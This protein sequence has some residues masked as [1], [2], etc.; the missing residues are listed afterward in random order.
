[1]FL[2]LIMQAVPLE[3]RSR[4]FRPG[5][6]TGRQERAQDQ[7]LEQDLIAKVVSSFVRD[8][9][10]LAAMM[11]AGIRRQRLAWSGRVRLGGFPGAI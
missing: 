6:L 7:L 9:L 1:M 2:P 5:G 3:V 8:A 11:H 4:A 10:I